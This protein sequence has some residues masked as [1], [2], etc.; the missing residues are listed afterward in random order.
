MSNGMV[1]T[2]ITYFENLSSSMDSANN[3]LIRK[4]S[5]KSNPDNSASKVKQIVNDFTEIKRPIK[6]RGIENNASNTYKTTSRGSAISREDINNYHKGLRNNSLRRSKNSLCKMKKPPFEENSSP[7]KNGFTDRQQKYESLAKEA[8]ETKV[9]KERLKQNEIANENSTNETNGQ[10]EQVTEDLN[11][12]DKNGNDDKLLQKQEVDEPHQQRQQSEDSRQIVE[13]RRYDTLYDS[14]KEREDEDG[15]SSDDMFGFNNFDGEQGDNYIIETYNDEGKELI[16]TTLEITRRTVEGDEC[17]DSIR[18]LIQNSDYVFHT[19]ESVTEK[20][21]IDVNEVSICESIINKCMKTSMSVSTWLPHDVSDD[22]EFSSESNKCNEVKTRQDG[23]YVKDDD[24]DVHSTCTFRGCL[25]SNREKGDNFYHNTTPSFD[26]EETNAADKR[27]DPETSNKS[28]EKKEKINYIIEE[29]IKTEELYI[30]GLD[31]IV[32]NYMP[33][34]MKETP[35]DLIGKTTYIFGNIELIYENAKQFLLLLQE[36][37]LDAEKIA[38]LFIDNVKMFEL[39]PLYSKNKPTADKVLKEFDEF[40]KKNVEEFKYVD[41]IQMSDLALRIFEDKPNV[42]HL[43]N[44]TKSKK[45][46]QDATYVLEAESPRIKN[47]WTSAI[48]SK[49]WLQLEN[50]KELQKKVSYCDHRHQKK[51]LGSVKD[52]TRSLDRNQRKLGRTKSRSTFYAQT[53]T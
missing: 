40:V 26:S 46:I 13:T 30:N 44:Y 22:E 10:Q 41:N 4:G 47:E 52:G 5:N 28:K 20:D 6:N 23:F 21:I 48:E 33:F 29:I 36:T 45:A 19:E 35:L 38:Q 3:G 17:E 16:I 37:G 31:I 32:N 42:F 34:L 7:N 27:D 43:T 50:A 14:E 15:E 24:D 53:D 12:S 1:K 51:L 9:N 39:Y 18:S 25:D 49:L 8:I 2:I 11:L